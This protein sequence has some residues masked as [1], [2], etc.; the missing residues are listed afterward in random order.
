MD[1]IEIKRRIP[2]LGES[3]DLFVIAN[4]KA[5]LEA[6]MARRTAFYLICAIL[7]ALTISTALWLR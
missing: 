7:L 3:G 1:E 2:M 5:E 4:H 6:A